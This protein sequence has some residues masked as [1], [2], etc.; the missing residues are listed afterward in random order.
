INDGADVAHGDV[1]AQELPLPESLTSAVLAYAEP[2]VPRQAL[3]VLQVDLNEPFGVAAPAKRPFRPV[4]IVPTNRDPV[5]LSEG[6]DGVINVA[7]RSLEPLPLLVRSVMTV[8]HELRL[9]NARLS[10]G[11]RARR[12]T[13]QRSR[14]RR[15]LEPVVVDLL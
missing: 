14:A 11:A 10:C 13:R 12:R 3:L 1:L 6:I 5:A 8:G 15:Q 9:A 4:V 2:E 7:E